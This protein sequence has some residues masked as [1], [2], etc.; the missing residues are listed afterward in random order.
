[1]CPK[2]SFTAL[3]LFLFFF[4]RLALQSSLSVDN[5]YTDSENFLVNGFDVDNYFWKSEP[6]NGKQSISTD[7]LGQ[8]LYF[9]YIKTRLN[10]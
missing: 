10:S 2:Q 8:V 1:M 3:M 4:I 6:D 9:H 7:F 5:F